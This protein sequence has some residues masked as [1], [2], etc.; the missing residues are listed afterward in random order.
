MTEWA[1]GTI[2]LL[3]MVRSSNETGASFTSLLTG[4]NHWDKYAIF[5]SSSFNHWADIILLY[6]AD[7]WYVCKHSGSDGVFIEFLTYEF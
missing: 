4:S 3:Y 1:A 7:L 6:I 5:A 2:S